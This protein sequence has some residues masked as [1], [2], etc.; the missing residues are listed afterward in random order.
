M[1][2]ASSTALGVDDVV[3]AIGAGG[4]GEADRARA[5]QT[6]RHLLGGSLVAA[7]LVLFGAVPLLAQVTTA[8]QVLTREQQATFLRTAEIEDVQDIPIGVT[9]SQHATLTDGTVSHRAH[10]QDV[11][12]FKRE[13]RAERGGTQINF[14]DSYKYNIAGHLLDKHLGLNM[15]PVSVE[16]EIQGRPYAVTWWI[17]DFAMDERE[18]REKQLQ[19]PDRLGW[20]YQ[21]SSVHVFNQ[22]IDNTDLNPGNLVIT[23]DWTVWMIDFTR[24]FRTFRQLRTPAVLTLCD[25][26]LLAGLRTLDEA[27]LAEITGEYLTEAEME[28]VAARAALIV[29]HFDNLIAEKGAGAV[30]FGQPPGD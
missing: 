28:G 9:E 26:A 17:D 30:L 20:L 2:S 4:M 14:H 12:I 11:D 29:E 1:M 15:V 23:H 7:G 10:L 6:V 3:P 24:A 5:R 8:V 27:V 22:L 13:F 19:A 16:R 21:M 25:R 18:R